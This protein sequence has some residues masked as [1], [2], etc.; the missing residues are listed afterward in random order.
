MIERSSMQIYLPNDRGLSPKTPENY[1]MALTKNGSL[2]KFF[3]NTTRLNQLTTLFQRFIYSPN[4]EYKA[5][6]IHD[7][8]TR[9]EFE[10]KKAVLSSNSKKEK[11]ELQKAIN[12]LNL[13]IET[14]QKSRVRIFQ[15]PDLKKCWKIT[16]LRI[17]E[18]DETSSK[19]N[20]LP[21]VLSI[22]NLMDMQETDDQLQKDLQPNDLSDSASESEEETTENPTPLSDDPIPPKPS[23]IPASKTPQQDK[24]LLLQDTPFSQPFSNQSS[25]PKTDSTEKI[26]F[27]NF[28][29]R[30]EKLG[31][32]LLI[33]GDNHSSYQQPAQ[34]K[35]EESFDD[36]AASVFPSRDASKDAAQSGALILVGN[37]GDSYKMPQHKTPKAPK[38]TKKNIPNSSNTKK[39]VVVE[40]LED[41]QK[42]LRKDLSS[43]NIL[44]KDLSFVN[45]VLINWALISNVDESH[46]ERMVESV[47]GTAKFVHDPT[48]LESLKSALEA[49]ASNISSPPYKCNFLQV[50]QQYLNIVIT[51]RDF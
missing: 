42:I 34:A 11:E 37:G 7:A 5:S 28:T 29:D 35:N 2:I 25:N 40:D 1:V 45:N 38:S 31:E 49:F 17:E 39:V 10:L 36:H 50:D 46:P 24:I 48:N 18:S 8:F 44:R 6:K 4:Y 16:P 14:Y 3:D 21:R 27:K 43:V 26:E 12:Y 51:A 47:V 9:T 13:F 19:P 23:E 33:G 20:A 41:L 22:P 30:R 32:I 15:D